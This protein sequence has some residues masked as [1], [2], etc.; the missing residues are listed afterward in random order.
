MLLGHVCGC[1]QGGLALF[2]VALL[3][4]SMLSIQKGINGTR[5]GVR[6]HWMGWCVSWCL[7]TWLLSP[8]LGSDGVSAGACVLGCSLLYSGAMVPPGAHT[9]KTVGSVHVL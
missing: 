5:S 1:L 3:L 7:R 6:L 4:H 9:W 8:L 2:A